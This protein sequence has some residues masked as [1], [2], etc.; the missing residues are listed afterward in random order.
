[1]T[2]GPLDGWDECT[3]PGCPSHDD[4]ATDEAVQEFE[5]SDGWAHGVLHVHHIDH[6][7]INTRANGDVQ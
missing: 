6:Y 1:V 7:L 5:D 4:N 2:A 3:E